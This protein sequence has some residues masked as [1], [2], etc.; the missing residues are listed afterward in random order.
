M[1]NRLNPI[2]EIG[3]NLGVN[4]GSG[5]YRVFKKVYYLLNFPSKIEKIFDKKLSN[6]GIILSD[7]IP[8]ERVKSFYAMFIPINNGHELI[9]IG[10]KGDGGYLLPNDLQDIEACYSPGSGDSWKFEKVLSEDFGIIS[11]VIDGT[12]DQP[13]GFTANQ[14]FQKVN[15]GAVSGQ[16]EISLRDWIELHNSESNNL[17]LQMDI[18]GS[19]YVC[20][21][22]L[23]NEILGR[24]RIIA[25]ELHDLMFCLASEAFIRQT[26]AMMEK[27]T[28]SHH[29]IHSHAN[30][31]GGTFSLYGREFPKVIE[32]TFHRKD[33]YQ[34]SNQKILPDRLD[35]RN[36]ESRP[37]FPIQEMF[38]W[39]KSN[40]SQS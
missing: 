26:E 39:V 6:H 17:L 25:L 13:K 28:K 27:L 30:N 18:E 40:Q 4:H 35:S 20:V 14:T 38:D 15:L 16:G 31:G 3:K 1:Q 9:R 8:I 29:L 7:R 21:N 2:K 24:F 12:I 32:L 33:R 10:G 11:H 37:E 22:S 19:E 23:E 36:I 5:M 34:R